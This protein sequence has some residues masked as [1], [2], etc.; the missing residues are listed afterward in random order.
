M[1]DRTYQ[2][3]AGELTGREV[4]RLRLQDLIVHTWDIGQSV[5]PPAALA[6]ELVQWGLA[7]LADP[8]SLTVQ[9]FAVMVPGDDAASPVQT[10]YLAA[11]GRVAV[12]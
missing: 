9:H 11:F 3:A 1:A 7:E 12:G 5:A 8:D 4:L 2:H 10:R 6:D